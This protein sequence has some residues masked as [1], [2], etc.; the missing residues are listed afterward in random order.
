MTIGVRAACAAGTGPRGTRPSYDDVGSPSRR[1]V[2]NHTIP[3]AS[4]L[5]AGSDSQNDGPEVKAKGQLS[6]NPVNA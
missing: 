4:Q 1:H 2:F 3:T 6:I 5:M